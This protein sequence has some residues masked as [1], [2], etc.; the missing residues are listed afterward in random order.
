M[1]VAIVFLSSM[2]GQYHTVKSYEKKCIYTELMEVFFMG[3]KFSTR[4]LSLFLSLLMVVTTIP[5]FAITANAAE[6]NRVIASFLTDTNHTGA[7]WTDEAGGSAYVDDSNTVT[8]GSLNMSSI[9]YGEGFTVRLKVKVDSAS[10]EDG[11]ILNFSGNNGNMY[12]QSGTDTGNNW[13]TFVL[14]IN[15]DGQYVTYYPADFDNTNYCYTDVPSDKFIWLEYS[16]DE[17]YTVQITMNSDGTLYYYFDNVLRAKFK[18]DYYNQNGNNMLPEN[19]VSAVSGLNTCTIGGNNF[20]GYVKDVY[21]FDKA[22]DVQGACNQIAQY[23]SSA[24]PEIEMYSSDGYDNVI[25]THGTNS[26]TDNGVNSASDYMFYGNQISDG[27]VNEAYQKQNGQETYKNVGYEQGERATYIGVPAGYTVNSAVCGNDTLTLTKDAGHISGEAASRNYF[28]TYY[29]LSG[30]LSDCT[31]S[32][33]DKTP[34]EKVITCS[35]TSPSGETFDKNFYVTVMPNPVSA[36]AMSSF[37]TSYSSGWSTRHREANTLMIA[38]GSVG[39]VVSTTN[40]QYVGNYVYLDNPIYLGGLNGWTCYDYN[41]NV[42]LYFTLGGSYNGTKGLVNAAGGF[43]SWVTSGNIDISNN[44]NNYTTVAANYYIDKSKLTNAKQ[45]MAGVSFDSSGNYSIDVL[46]GEVSGYTGETSDRVASV[47]SS[48]ANNITWNADVSSFETSGSLNGDTH[49]T[50]TNVSPVPNGT[51]MKNAATTL[52]G[53]VN[54]GNASITSKFTRAHDSNRTS[55]SLLNVYV[56]VFDKS[57]VYDLVKAYSNLISTDYTTATWNVFETALK[58]ATYYCNNYLNTDTSRNAELKTALENAY[59]QL[60]SKTDIDSYFE[61]FNSGKINDLSGYTLTTANQYIANLN[62]LEKN[63]FPTDWRASTKTKAAYSQLAGAVEFL[64]TTLNPLATLTDYTEYTTAVSAIE[65]GIFS[66]T[67][68]VYTLESWKQLKDAVDSIN[69]ADLGKY[70]YTLSSVEFDGSSYSY[71][72]IDN[73]QNSPEVEQM[74]TTLSALSTLTSLNTDILNNFDAACEV[75]LTMPSVKYE[76]TAYEAAMAQVDSIKNTVYVSATDNGYTVP[77]G[78]NDTVVYDVQDSN[79]KSILNIVSSL[80]ENLAYFDVRITINNESND[81][82]YTY[83]QSVTL[84]AQTVPGVWTIS[85]AEKTLT[86]TVPA[87]KEALVTVESAFEA[88]FAS[89][90][91]GEVSAQYTV[92]ICDAFGKVISVYYTD[93]IPTSNKITATPMTIPFYNFAGWTVTSDGENVYTAVPTYNF[94]SD[95]G[96]YQINVNSQ[97]FGEYSYDSKVEIS[98]EGAYGWAN[99]VDGKYQIVSYNSTYSFHVCADGDYYPIYKQDGSYMVNGDVLTASNVEYVLPANGQSTGMN[100]D[101]YLNYKLDNKLPFIYVE[102]SYS[103][104]NNSKFRVYA[105]ITDGADVN[106]YGV[107]VSLG[108]DEHNFSCSNITDTN[109]YMFTVT[110]RD[111]QSS[112]VELSP[113]I[114]YDFNYGTTAINAIDTSSYVFNVQ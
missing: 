83:G 25:Y 63:Y 8:L 114:N 19:Q 95:S 74:K 70:S 41:S 92:N 1:Y 77:V 23:N 66:G 86:L 101:D 57:E 61:A 26:L 78:V 11:R 82:T 91:S 37:Y 22:L 34:R 60:L 17:W 103:F 40:D 104:E 36:N 18:Y 64:G 33:N 79:V 99:K 87:N 46:L 84:P 2:Y 75:V 52:T 80:E 45:D 88:E 32:D 59:N 102:N 108:G 6:E 73:S 35:I 62:E 14:G 56:N 4:I 12:L 42:K 38:Q 30:T 90:V 112:T 100:V 113:Y 31:F 68:Q 7:N 50:I 93:E 72:S 94:L 48:N 43:D 105:R 65:N 49:N 29:L 20:Q 51:V 10:S 44:S 89:S 53:N 5:A 27:T 47:S 13:K 55:N 85:S 69:T 106:A 24:A 21:V 97:L 58:N 98:Q 109:Q 9:N 71:Y 15:K 81:S 107:I 16:K 96:M 111:L 54:N 67:T 3:N 28:D 76:K 110:I 39:S